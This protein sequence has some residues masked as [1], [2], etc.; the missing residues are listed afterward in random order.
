[1]IDKVDEARIA[2]AI[3][4]VEKKTSGE[5]VVV[6]GRSASGYRLVPIVWASIVTLALPMLLLA[7][8]SLT[9]RTLYEIELFVFGVLAFV[10]SFGR[11][12]YQLVPGWIKRGRAHEAAHEQFLA[13]RISH[14]RAR[15]GVLVYV[16]L[17]EHYAELVPD[18]GISDIIDDQ[19]WK[20]V[21]ERLKARL[22]EGRIADG[23]I[24]IIEQSGTMLAEKLP[25]TSDNPDELPNAVILL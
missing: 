24:E 23:I 1:M 8:F 22:R 17:A 18:A 9:G 11:Y 15:T 3:A 7:I 6:V 13:R 10:L 14:T 5:I 16:A 21:V 25:P 4:E 12:R 20:P 19:L 2:T